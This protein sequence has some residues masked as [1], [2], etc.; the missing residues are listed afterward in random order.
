[1][2]SLQTRDT[3]TFA[4]DTTVGAATETFTNAATDPSAYEAMEAWIAWLNAA[5]RAWFGTR[6]FSWTW[7]RYTTDGGAKIT[8]SATGGVFSINAG[9]N[10]RLKLAAAAGVTTTTGTAGADGTWAPGSKVN[11]T[12][13]YR[14]LEPRGDAAAGPAVRGAAPGLAPFGPVVEAVGD[15]IDTARLASVLSNASHPRRAWIWQVPFSA[16]REYAL[17]P[18]S[19]QRAEPLLWRMV[20]TCAGPT[21]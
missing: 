19:V 10:G 4:V 20:L 5:G 16:W 11:V 9:A 13:H 3:W 1:M 14:L 21:V 2:L 8:L 12:R 17:G 7:A 15:S 18:V 6:T